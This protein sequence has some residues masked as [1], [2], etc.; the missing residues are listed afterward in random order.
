[1][2]QSMLTSWLWLLAGGLFA[3]QL[4]RR[5][6]AP[7]LLGMVLVGMVLGPEVADVFAP[8][9]LESADVLRTLAV[10][11]I[12]MKAGLGLSVE[13]LR[14]Q[15]SVTLRLGFLPAGCE[16][17][18]LMLLARMFFDLPLLNAL[19]LGCLLSAES[20]AVI[21]PGMLRLKS[22]G[23]G[24]DKGIPDAVMTG[25][26]LSDVLVLALFS[27]LLGIL[28][29]EQA[30]DVL[31]GLHPLLAL[32]LQ[33]L[34]QVTLGLLLGYVVARLLLWLLK[35]STWSQNRFY[36]LLL[37][38]LSALALVVLAEAQPYFSGYLAVMTLGLC[39]LRG[40]MPLARRLRQGF[41]NLWLL[42]E[43]PLFVLLG[44]SVALERMA[45]L[46]LPGLLLLAAGTLLGRMAG[47]LLATWGS[48]WTWME[49]LFLL[50]ANSA[51][52]TVQAALGALP[53][54]LGIEGGELMLAMAALSIVVTAPLGAWAIGFFAPRWLERGEVDPR[55]VNLSTQSLLLSAVD[56]SPLAAEVLRSSAALARRSDAEVLVLHVSDTPG[57][58]VV[59]LEQQSQHWLSDIPHRFH[60]L[61]GPVAETILAVA[62]QYQAAEIILGK[63][64]QRPL[65]QRLLGSVAEDVLAASRYPVILIEAPED[66]AFEDSQASSAGR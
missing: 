11:L 18:L 64:G 43:I 58:A 42:A 32:V 19:L 17:L 54:A 21:V 20:P 8:A 23:W 2:Q 59:W 40:D 28:N 51:K 45:A 60:V 38:V 55:S 35:R 26:A 5:F 13:K 3:G 61:P 14:Q 9:L 47:W 48:D 62:D 37:T 6:G 24:V 50:P 15:G 34:L 41:D 12:L 65:P 25:S 56:D 63:H 57:E 10:M 4:A 29:P 30:G 7:A 49:R 36:E 44:A 53:L 33:L 31:T 1:M 52:A 66:S 46:W 16:A 39:L 22:L 27:L